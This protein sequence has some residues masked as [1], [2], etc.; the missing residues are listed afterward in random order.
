M[1]RTC[2]SVPAFQAGP[3]NWRRQ[4]DSPAATIESAAPD[5]PC[6]RETPPTP[7]PESSRV[8]E[9]SLREP[10]PSSMNN[11]SFVPGEQRLGRAWLVAALS[12]HSAWLKMFLACLH[13][14][15]LPSHIRLRETIS[16]AMP[17]DE[18]SL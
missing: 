11:L 16:Q 2:R 9:H 13:Y 14:R 15:R 17:L 3:R 7:L 6:C 10:Q 1:R 18:P 12:C 8:S 5:R 4:V